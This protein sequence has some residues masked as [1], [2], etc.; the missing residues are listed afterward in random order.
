MH[1]G[2]ESTFYG[3]FEVFV[4]ISWDLLGVAT[5]AVEKST[6]EHRKW[7]VLSPLSLEAFQQA[8]ETKIDQVGSI[9]SWSLLKVD[10]IEALLRPVLVVGDLKILFVGYL[11]ADLVAQLLVN[12]IVDNGLADL[13]AWKFLH[14]FVDSL[15]LG[16]CFASTGVVQSSI[17]RGD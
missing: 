15:D 7:L 10:V 2:V 14:F 9:F 11:C 3:D 6:V 5:D 8:G 4:L 1:G 12:F 17:C 16:S 13:A